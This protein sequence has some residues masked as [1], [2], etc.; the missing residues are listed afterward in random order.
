MGAAI[1]VPEDDDV[2]RSSGSKALLRTR[3]SEDERDALRAATQT[4]VK[5]FNPLL[6]HFGTA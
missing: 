6:G 1:S 3:C 5:R 2:S 4:R